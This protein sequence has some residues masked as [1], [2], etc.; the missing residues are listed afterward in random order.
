[1][2]QKRTIVVIRQAEQLDVP[3]QLKFIKKM[4]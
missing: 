2:E 1:M 3:L 4:L